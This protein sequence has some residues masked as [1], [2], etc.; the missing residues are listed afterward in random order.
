LGFFDDHGDGALIL[1]S[2]NV[3]YALTGPP[4]GVGG[5]M[6]AGVYVNFK[7]WHVMRYLMFGSI[8]E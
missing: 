7:A 1:K 4:D 8:P 3:K 2:L 5:E 6:V